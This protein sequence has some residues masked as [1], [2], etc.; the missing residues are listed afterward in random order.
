MHM[1]VLRGVADAMNNRR[2]LDTGAAL[3]T[4]AFERY[5]ADRLASKNW[6]QLTYQRKHKPAVDLFREL[7][8]DRA[9]TAMSRR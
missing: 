9:P 6:T 1:A 8:A 3:Q 5:A 2:R 7:V 4:E